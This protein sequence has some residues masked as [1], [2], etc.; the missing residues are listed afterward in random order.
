MPPTIKLFS[1]RKLQYNVKSKHWSSENSPLDTQQESVLFI[2]HQ[3][4]VI[5][6]HHHIKN[7]F[8]VKVV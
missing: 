6:I 2:S 7:P 8:L 1:T 4:C 3:N 5:E